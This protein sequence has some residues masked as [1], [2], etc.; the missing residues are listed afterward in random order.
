MFG[1]LLALKSRVLRR[2]RKAVFCSEKGLS[3]S[4]G[5][6]NKEVSWSEKNNENY[7]SC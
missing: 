1:S 5:L 6:L 3:T 7:S 4:D 2:A